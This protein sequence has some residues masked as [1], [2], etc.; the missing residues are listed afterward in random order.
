M[1]KILFMAAF[2]VAGVT[3]SIAATPASNNSLLAGS[4][5]CYRAAVDDFGN[6]YYVK[7]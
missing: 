4:T 7:K 2:V 5:V 3:G 1:K 6:V